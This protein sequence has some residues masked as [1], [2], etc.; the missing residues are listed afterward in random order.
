[1]AKRF[2]L[3]GLLRLRRLQEEQAAAELARAHAVKR[4]AEKRRQDTEDMLAGTMLPHRSD[5]LSWRAAIAG[6]AALTGL[7]GEAA[8]AVDLA[9]GRVGTATGEWSGAR[10]RATTLSKLEERHDQTVRAEE[11]RAE[12]VVLDEVASRRAHRTSTSS[13]TEEER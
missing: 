6:R 13:P 10:T 9:A 12:Q 8:I 3:G 1:M 5:E 11:S 4:S 7:A 2:R